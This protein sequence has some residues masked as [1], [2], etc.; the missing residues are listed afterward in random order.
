MTKNN[1][2][3]PL[4]IFLKI[5]MALKVRRDVLFTQFRTLKMVKRK[6]CLK[7]I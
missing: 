1:P 3:R 5:E 2:Q 4:E 7:Q 6:C